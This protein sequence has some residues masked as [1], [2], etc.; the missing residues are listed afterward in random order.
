[1]YTDMVGYTALG[2]KDEPLSLAMVEAQQKI[3]GPVLTRHSG[4]VVKTMGDAFLVEFTNAL[5]AARCAYDVQ[6][7]V[8]EFNLA[9]S[10]EKRIHLRVGIHLG[11]V[12]EKEGD[13]FGDA[14]NV[15]SRIEPLAEDGGV[16]LT[17]QVY[18]HVHNK[19]EF[20]L[21]SIGRKTL[22]NVSE[23]VEVY[24][25]EMPWSG[26]KAAA[27]AQLDKNRVAV[28][29][30]ANI[31][32]DPNDE[33]LA[34]GMTEEL[35]TAMSGLQGLQVIARTSVMNYKKKEK[36]VSEIGKELRVG[37]V[38]EGSVRKAGNKVRVTAQLIDVPTESHIWSDRYD[39]ELDDIFA[40]Q[41]DIAGKIAGALRIKLA[42]VQ[43]S[44]GKQ[45]ENMEAYTL[46]LKGRFLWNKRDKEGVLESVK[47]FHEAIRIDPDY[48]RAYSGL[49]DA[50]YIAGTFGFMDRA[51]GLARSKEAATRALELD[52]T[53]AEAH[54]SLGVN[55]WDDLRFDEA[56]REFRRAIELNPGYATAHHWYFACLLDMGMRKEAA[57]EIEKAHELDPLSTVITYNVGAMHL[58]CGRLDEAIAIYDK[59][60]EKDPT[61]PTSYGGRAHCFM[62]KGMKE[63]AYAD[64]EAWHRLRKDEDE[65]KVNLAQL[66][67]WFGE[68]EK[69][70]SMIEELI[71]KV[72]KSSGLELGITL[73]YAVLG[74]RDEFFK[75]IDKAIPA[76]MID[77]AGLRYL[78]DYHKVRD[79]PRFPEIFKKLG[80]PY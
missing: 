71:P 22:K 40:I 62:R 26:E 9:L 38:L 31:S 67:G 30:F 65:Y 45:T 5:E 52:D 57:E 36:N 75:W 55:Y 39:R 74:D 60:I 77:P 58:Y 59:L 33:Y 76:K 63:R 80:L 70:L 73:C 20:P 27:T 13:I 66:Y 69:T 42:S 2:Q 50:F 29:P 34:D 35:I 25:M 14:V 3:L 15:A 46:Y 43:E 10:S 64:L 79:D 18:D 12:V 68:R 28:L 48:A 51:D 41:S 6:R 37:T 78:P 7:S 53:L 21:T 19:L 8:R 11:D 16:C 24:R 72:G 56:H 47:L 49:A 17:Q 1:M 23:P 54:A 4:R 61:F 44:G 32:P